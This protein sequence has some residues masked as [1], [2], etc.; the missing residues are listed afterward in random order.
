MTYASTFLLAAAA[1]F[2][3]YDDHGVPLFVLSLL[4]SHDS[5]SLGADH[6]TGWVIW[7]GREIFFQHLDSQ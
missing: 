4:G 1:V 5:V 2:G 7:S 3:C 6:S